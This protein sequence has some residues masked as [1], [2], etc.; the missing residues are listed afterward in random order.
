MK[1]VIEVS[2]GS[3]NFSVEDDAYIRLK[4]YMDRFRST[5]A[6]PAEAKEIMEDVEARV[7]EIFQREMKYSNQVIDANMVQV[8]I[9]QLGELEVTTTREQQSQSQQASQTA[10]EGYQIGDKRLF[11]DTENKMLGGVCSGL[12]AYFDID[13]TLARILLVIAFFTFSAGFWVY[14]IMWMVMPQAKT[15]PDKLA[16][17]GYATTAEN[18]R[19]YT[20][21]H[22]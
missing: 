18:I 11:R 21:T 14:I 22:K 10:N 9:D 2:I 12:G 20:N 8:V 3:I 19:R 13:P 15:I 16:M 5:I 1:K 7:A 6:D 4:N 17:H